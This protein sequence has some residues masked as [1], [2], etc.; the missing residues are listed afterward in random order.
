MILT[1][2]SES[3]VNWTLKLG[4]SA[5]RR[6]LIKSVG[7]L[8]FIRGDGVYDE[9]TRQTANLFSDLEIYAR[10]IPSNNFKVFRDSHRMFGHE[11][12]VSVL[13]NNQS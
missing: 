4:S 13:S 2:S 11:K 12:V 5:M 9:T 1:N 10:E 6:K 3:K 7:N 8:L